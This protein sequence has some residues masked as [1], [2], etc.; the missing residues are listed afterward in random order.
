MIDSTGLHPSSCRYSAGRFSRHSALNDIMKRARDATGTHSVLE[1]AKLDGSDGRRQDSITVFPFLQS[2]SVMWH[3]TCFDTFAPSLI[4]ASSSFTGSAAAAAEDSTRRKYASLA[5][6]YH[7]IP[8]TVETSGV[9]DPSAITLIKE[10][11][12]SIAD[13]EDDSRATSFLFLSTSLV[14][15]RGNSFSILVSGTRDEFSLTGL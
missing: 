2:K 7:F 11:T 4:T 6:S 13:R 9:I 1:Q 12:H 3:S 8:F 15:V 10:V 14:I 5:S